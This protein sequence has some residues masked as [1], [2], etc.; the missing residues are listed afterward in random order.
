MGDRI[1]K[2]KKSSQKEG[3]NSLISACCLWY[4]LT[5]IMYI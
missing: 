5:T 2:V 4:N 1:E 3:E